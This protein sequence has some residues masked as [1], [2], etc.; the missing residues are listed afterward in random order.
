MLKRS[1]WNSN[2]FSLGSYSY[3]KTGAFNE[4][5]I[6]SQ[7]VNNKLYFAGEASNPKYI[8]TVHGAHISGR[9]AAYKITKHLNE[10]K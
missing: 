1:K 2:Q 10:N 9:E 3:V 6:Y 5:K 7:T 4:C 8:G